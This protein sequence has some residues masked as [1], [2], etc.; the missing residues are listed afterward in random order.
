MA[1]CCSGVRG[2]E[3]SKR[4][5]TRGGRAKSPGLQVA[6]PRWTIVLGQHTSEVR[7][8]N[9]PCQCPT[10]GSRFKVARKYATLKI[11]CPKCSGVIDVPKEQDSDVVPVAQAAGGP[12]PQSARP[13]T[14]AQPPETSLPPEVLAGRIPKP[15]PRAAPSI[16]VTVAK[17][18]Q[19]APKS[20]PTP[21]SPALDTTVSLTAGSEDP[22]AAIDNP[23]K[24]PESLFGLMSPLVQ[25]PPE[26]PDSLPAQTPEPELPIAPQ[27][28]SFEAGEACPSCGVAV[29]ADESI[30]PDAAA[31][32]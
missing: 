20:Q 17:P 25:M 29:S 11:K 32:S 14:P 30:C 16:P 15:A 13:A 27:D 10:C 2:S 24:P 31:I 6:L 21:T 23:V 22:R 1:K 7:S 8:V 19:A 3:S 5:E 12:A 4:L 26:D 28:E 9:I 18:P